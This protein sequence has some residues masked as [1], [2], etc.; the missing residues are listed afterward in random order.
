MKE[1]NSRL[2]KGQLE[3]TEYRVRG[4]E[5]NSDSWRLLRG[6]REGYATSLILF[7]TYHSAAMRQ[8][9]EE[10]GKSVQERTLNVGIQFS[11]RPGNSLPSKSTKQAIKSTE[12]ET[13]RLTEALFTQ[14][15]T[16]YGEKDE[17]RQCKEIVQLSMRSFEEKLYDGKEE[18]LELGTAAGGE[19]R[20]LETR[21]G[22]KHDPRQRKRGRYALMTT[23]KD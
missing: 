6:L 9:A 10:R 12:R 16:P 3:E 15:A 23:K 19:I 7:N 2:L 1:D 8:V 18:H 14:D 20:M 4:R 5:E 17:M 11:W 22:R 13:F 21:V